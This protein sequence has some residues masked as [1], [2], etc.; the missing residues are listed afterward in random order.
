MVNLSSRQVESKIAT[1]WLI[2][3]A[4]ADHHA[5]E[6]EL[7]PSGRGCFLDVV[8]SAG[9]DRKAEAGKGICFKKLSFNDL[10]KGKILKVCILC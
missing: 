6:S 4:T 7:K 9:K 2:L 1:K 5:I 3:S 8:V 10:R